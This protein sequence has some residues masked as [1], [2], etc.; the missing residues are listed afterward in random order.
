LARAICAANSRISGGSLRHY[1]GN[2]AGAVRADDPVQYVLAVTNIAPVAV[3]SGQS[4]AIFR[5][6]IGNPIA[7][8]IANVQ[9]SQL[10]LRFEQASGIALSPQ[11]AAA[12]ISD[13]EIHKDANGNNSY[14]PVADPLVISVGV[15]AF[16]SDGVLTVSFAEADP[17]D[18]LV[19][20]GQFRS[21]FAVVRLKA[22]AASANPNSFR[23]THLANGPYASAAR[24]GNT[25]QTLTTARLPMSLL[26]L[27]P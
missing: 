11:Q 4:T 7:G 2:A 3:L 17:S 10:G 22:D 9:V 20:A 21:Y 6:T 16:T 26:R 12:L 24:D 25:G 8:G 5:M 14:E 19:V 18:L 27:S 15:P 1:C 13:V 23:V